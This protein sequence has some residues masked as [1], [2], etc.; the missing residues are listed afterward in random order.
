MEIL[1]I[2]VV[3]AVIA[4]VIFYNKNPKALDV[5]KDGK[6]NAEDAKVAVKAVKAEVKEAAAEVKTEAKKTVAKAK[7][8]AKKVTE[9]AKAGRKPKVK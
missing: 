8:S 2:A 5:N 1:V 9:K 7:A 3:I 4:G 6:V